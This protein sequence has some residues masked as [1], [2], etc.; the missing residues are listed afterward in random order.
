MMNDQFSPHAATSDMP[1]SPRAAA[2]HDMPPAQPTRPESQVRR[3][4]NGRRQPRNNRFVP[5]R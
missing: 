3:L 1:L 5:F 4:P 2:A